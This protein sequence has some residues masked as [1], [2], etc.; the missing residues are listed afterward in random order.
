VRPA[1]GRASARLVRA[2]GASLPPGTIQAGDTVVE[3]F[4]EIGWEWGGTWSSPDYQH[5]S[6][7]HDQ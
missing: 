6:T 2:A 5:F 1:A 7:G 3:A 4:A